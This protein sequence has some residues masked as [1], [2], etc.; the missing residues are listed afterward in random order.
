M[1]T[2]AD[3]KLLI[4]WCFQQLAHIA[5][6]YHTTSMLAQRLCSRWQ[7]L[8]VAA[9]TPCGSPAAGLSLTVRRGPRLCYPS[10]VLRDLRLPGSSSWAQHWQEVSIMTW[11]ARNLQAGRTQRQ[12]SKCDSGRT[13]SFARHRGTWRRADKGH[14]S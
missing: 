7:A 1:Q 13:G 2:Q 3:K 4:C 8:D 12:N 6:A 5:C 9:A 10:E 11:D 14:E